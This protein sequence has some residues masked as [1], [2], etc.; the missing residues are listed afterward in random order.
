L[1]EA[2]RSLAH[3]FNTSR[4]T[5]KTWVVDWRAHDWGNDPFALGAYSFSVAGLDDGPEVLA[6]P[7]R[8]TLFFAGEATAEELGTVHGALDSGLRAAREVV[9]AL[10]S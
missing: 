7:L 2:L 5:L 6:K 1:Q 8:D 10:K 9:A 3:L 4:K